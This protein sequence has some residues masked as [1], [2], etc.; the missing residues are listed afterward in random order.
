MEN[1]QQEKW[2]EKPR[3]HINTVFQA[4]TWCVKILVCSSTIT[5]F[6]YINIKLHMPESKST[7]V[8]NSSDIK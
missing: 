2:T 8:I 1:D 4:A 6:V 7:D 3:S 5:D